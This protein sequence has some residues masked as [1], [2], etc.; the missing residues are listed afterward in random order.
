MLARG[1]YMWKPCAYPL[2]HHVAALES[3]DSAVD[4]DADAADSDAVEGV[5]SL[6]C[7]E[8]EDWADVSESEED[9]EVDDTGEL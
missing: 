2:E 7:D 4:S 6:S 3:D 1:S 5:D 9:S 8:E